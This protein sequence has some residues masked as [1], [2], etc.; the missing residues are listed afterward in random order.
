M[1]YPPI[2]IALVMVVAAT[3]A[4]AA[5]DTDT[6][7]LKATKVVIGEKVITITAEARTTV[8]IFS[9]EDDPAHKGGTLRGKPVHTIKVY[10][11]SGTFTIM[12]PTDS[13]DITANAWKMSVDA[14]ESLKAGNEVG[15]IGYYAPN[16]RFQE[17]MLVS[18][19]G[20]GFL[21]PKG[22]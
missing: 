22:D 20:F 5:S 2:S 18:I 13:S 14:A 17:N 10:S 12:R 21:Y 3:P 16:M 6:T 9:G 8:R 7:I 1:K 11:R 19:T 15:R 4:K